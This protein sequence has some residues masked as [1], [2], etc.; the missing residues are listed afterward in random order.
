MYFG[1]MALKTTQTVFKPCSK[2]NS[3]RAA[4]SGNP[5]QAHEG[6]ENLQEQSA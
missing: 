5:F 2:E 1:C 4:D 3:D 6:Q